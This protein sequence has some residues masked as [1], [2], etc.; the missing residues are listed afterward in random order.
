MRVVSAVRRV[1]SVDPPNLEKSFCEKDMILL[2][3]SL[4]TSHVTLALRYA[5][6]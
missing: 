4:R 5:L 1:M 2:K 3:R 6:R